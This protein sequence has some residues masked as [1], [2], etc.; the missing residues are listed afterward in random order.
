[1]KTKTYKRKVIEF[2]VYYRRAWSGWQSAAVTDY[3]AILVHQ[4]TLKMSYELIV[5]RPV[6]T[7][8]FDYPLHNP[9]KLTFCRPT[10]F[11]RRDLIACVHKGYEKIY[12][13]IRKYGVWGHSMSDLVLVGMYRKSPGLYELGIDS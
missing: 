5:A 2:E 4:A 9:T 13:N 3:H 12:S 10:G 8:E 11:T 1:M 7:I 6:I